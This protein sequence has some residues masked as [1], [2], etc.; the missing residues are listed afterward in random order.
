MTDARPGGQPS[1]GYASA[2]SAHDVT[3]AER[4]AR[5]GP[6]AS[7]AILAVA[8]AAAIAV[9]TVALS[10]AV[11][12]LIRPTATTTG[13]PAPQFVEEAIAAGIEHAY[14]GEFTF[15]VGGGVAAFDCDADLRP[16]LYLA[17]GS[18]PAALFRNRTETGAAL[19]FERTADPVTDLT[20]VT[21]AYP[22]DID[23]DR[24][25]DLVVLRRGED[26][27]LR[28]L[29]DCR[30][31]RGNEALG[32][33]GGDAWTVGFSATWETPSATLPTLAFG[34]YVILDEQQSADGC[35]DNRLIRPTGNGATYAA[36][37]PL[38]PGWCTLSMLFSDWDRS[39]RRDLRVSNDRHYY[40]DGEE[41]LWR[42]EPGA[43]PRAYGRE[44]GWARLQVWGMGIASHDLTGD[45]YPEVYLTSQGDNKLQTLADGPARPI[46][47][48]IALRRGA[49]AHRPFVGEVALPS[50][51]WHAEFDDVN[52]DGYMD[53]FVAK[54]NVDAMQ[55]FAMKDPSNLLLGQADGT[56]VE[57]AEA[58]GLL[59]YARARGAALTD[60]DLDGLLDLVVVNRRENVKVYRNVGAGSAA[61]PAAMGRWIQVRLVQEGPNRDAIGA[62]LEVKADDR[63]TMRELTVGGGHAS[64][65][66]GWIHTGLGGAERAEVR[67]RWPDGEL[68]P[69]LPL[70]ADRF[71]II[72]RG[73]DA[74][75][76]WSPTP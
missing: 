4:T 70:E 50:T 19:R 49:T 51:A 56:F 47:E 69:W 1:R 32:F 64:G 48:D 75:S 38:S 62:W 17:G 54:G 23:G 66:L 22:I 39:G 57:A 14:Q 34:D 26:V 12:A 36:P 52:A 45:G 60:L 25:V 20:S 8:L 55:E 31:E 33:A 10:G 72:E 27:I 30:F 40:R 24:L 68:G 18:E 21:G 35:P 37:V 65:E 76:P 74:V 5:G 58:A 6:R 16:E 3:A 61:A 73:A 44:D 13:L 41:Q 67:V 2:V 42:I 46:F 7:R 59:S 11:P 43:A 63:I 9:A 29:G 28:G 53:L 15:F 71:G